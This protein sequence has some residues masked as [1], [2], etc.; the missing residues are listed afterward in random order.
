MTN[1][2]TSIVIGA[3]VVAAGYFRLSGE[4]LFT[5]GCV[6]VIGGIGLAVLRRKVTR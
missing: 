4:G 5:L 1:V 3:A 6:L 2:S